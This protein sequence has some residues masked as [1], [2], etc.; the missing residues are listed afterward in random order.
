MSDILSDTA[1]IMQGR[2][3]T[4]LTQK[5]LPGQVSFQT[6]ATVARL[7]ATA[8]TSGLSATQYLSAGTAG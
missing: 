3:A 8:T 4:C 7:S 5:C 6:L 1:D 2:Q